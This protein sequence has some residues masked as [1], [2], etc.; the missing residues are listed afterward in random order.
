MHGT[1]M[2][3]LRK[4]KAR[5]PEHFKGGVVLEYGSRDINGTPRPLFDSP[6]KYVGIDCHEGAGVD[7]VGICHEYTEMEEGSCDVVVSTEMLEHDPYVEETVAAAWKMLKPGGIFLGTCAG[8][9][10]GAHHLEDS[11]VPGYYGGVDPEDIKASLAHNG[12]W[13]LIEA[14]FVRGKLDTTWCAVKA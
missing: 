13:S 9:L 6:E 8:R 11:P 10:R 4:I 14:S 2:E 1:V 7:W 5:Y 12:E 3:Y